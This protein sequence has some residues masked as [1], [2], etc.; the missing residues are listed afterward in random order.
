MELHFYPGTHTLLVKDKSKV[1]SK[2]SAWGGPATRGTDSY[3]AEEPTTPGTYLIHSSK[4]YHTPTWPMSKI[5]WGTEL[6]DMPKDS[7]VWYKLPGGKWGSVKRDIGISRMK[8][9]KLNKELYGWSRV[10]EKWVFN[11]FGPISIR[12]FKDLNGNEE[13]DG[14]EKLSGQMFHTTP[15][16]EAEQALG[17]PVELES[18]HGCIHLKPADRDSLFSLGAFNPKTK[19]VVHEY[20][21]VP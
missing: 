21:E 8:L 2:F 6:R 1:K 9:I 13:L 15:G 20:D 4:P 19:F 3:M 18:S 5:V 14:N 11:D 12:W 10:P 16:N 7:D 17:K